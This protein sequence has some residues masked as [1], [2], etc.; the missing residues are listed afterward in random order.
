MLELVITVAVLSIVIMGWS[1]L[2]K[3]LDWI[4]ARFGSATDIIDHLSVSATKQTSR[5]VIISDTSL[6][7]TKLE[8]IK[9]KQ[10]FINE[11]KD[12]IKGLNKEE[13]TEIKNYEDWMNNL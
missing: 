1:K 11:R 2:S 10:Q 4:G 8:G 12:L 5:A 13:T 9:A 3:A 6:D 7:T